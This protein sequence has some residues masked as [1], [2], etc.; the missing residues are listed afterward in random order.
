[1]RRFLLH[2]QHQEG[3]LGLGRFSCVFNSFVLSE[4]GDIVY[5]PEGAKA[6]RYTEEL[7]AHQQFPLEIYKLQGNEEV[8]AVISS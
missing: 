1:M 3:L 7:S 2:L 8:E 6:L 5:A 4:A